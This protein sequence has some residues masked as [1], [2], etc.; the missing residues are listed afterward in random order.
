MKYIYGQHKNIKPQD[1]FYMG[2]IAGA[3]ALRMKDKIGRLEPGFDADIAVIKFP[4]E[5]ISNIFDGIFFS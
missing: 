2:T 3:I 1:I 4:E 5:G